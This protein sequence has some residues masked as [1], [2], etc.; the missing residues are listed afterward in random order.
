MSNQ[1][2]LAW[3]DVVQVPYILDHDVGRQVFK[4]LLKKGL[5]GRKVGAILDYF[6]HGA[7]TEKKKKMIF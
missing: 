1:E 2:V 5:W 6:W 4:P 7:S 3:Q